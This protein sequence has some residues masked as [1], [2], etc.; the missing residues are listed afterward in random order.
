MVIKERRTYVK[1]GANIWLHSIISQIPNGAFIACLMATENKIYYQT[2]K[3][4]KDQGKGKSGAR[5]RK[6]GDKTLLRWRRRDIFD[7]VT[8]M[9]Q[10]LQRKGPMRLARRAYAVR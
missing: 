6:E 10:P 2:L 1:V 9:A 5:Y 8:L 4:N 7:N 3:Q